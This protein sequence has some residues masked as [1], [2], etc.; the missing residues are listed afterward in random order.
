MSYQLGRPTRRSRCS[1]LESSRNTGTGTEGSVWHALNAVTEWS[2]HT[3]RV[4]GDDRANRVY[5]N[6]LGTSA[7]FKAGAFALAEAAAG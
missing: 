5:S 3:R 4:R 6:L 1:N 2:D 7:A